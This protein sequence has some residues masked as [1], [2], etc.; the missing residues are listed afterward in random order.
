[1]EIPHLKLL[2]FVAGLSAL[3]RVYMAFQAA[4]GN[5]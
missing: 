1:M 3:G 5:A 4:Q 2:T